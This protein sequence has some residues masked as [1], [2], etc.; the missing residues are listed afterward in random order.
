MLG[1]YNKI[2]EL[3]FE[4]LEFLKLLKCFFLCCILVFEVFKVFEVFFVFVFCFVFLS[5][6][7]YKVYVF[8]IL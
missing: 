5:C 1:L 8:V 6:N 2:V 4:Y 7:D 3:A